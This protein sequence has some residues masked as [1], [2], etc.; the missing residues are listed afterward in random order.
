MNGWL[1]WA[2]A[3]LDGTVPHAAR[4]AWDEYTRNTL[5]A[6]ADAFPRHWDGT[7]SVDDACNAYYASAPANCGVNLFTDYQGQITEQPTWM[8]MNA[9]E[10]RGR[11]GHAGRLPDRPAPGPPLLACASRAWE[12]RA[13]G[14]SC[15][16][17]CGCP[18]AA[19]WSSGCACREARAA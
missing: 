7:I 13:P 6:H 15:A 19:G 5:A 10:P 16:A 9:T 3:E 4:Y 2:L 11:Q 12:W 8:V 18:R 1:T 14:T 17:T